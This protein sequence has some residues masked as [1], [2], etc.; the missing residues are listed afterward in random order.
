MLS[1]MFYADDAVFVGQ[2]CESNITTL[3]H[4][5]VCFHRAFGLKIN[6][7]KSK[8]LG[9]HMDS[10]RVKEVA[11]KLGCLTLKFPFLYL[12]MMVG[13][14]MS[15]LHEWD[16]VVERVKTRLSKWKMKSLSIGG[17]SL[18]IRVIQAIYGEDGKIDADVK[19]GS[20]S[21]WL[22]IVHEAKALAHKGIDLRDFMRIKLGNGENTRFWEDSW[23]E[24]D[25]L[26]NRFPRLYAL[27]SCKR[28]TEQFENLVT[29]V[30]DVS[31]SPMADRWSWTLDISRDFTVSSVRKWIDDKL[32]PEVGSKT[33][34][35][36]YVLIIVNVNAWKVKLDVFPTR[37][38]LSRRGIHIDFIMCVICDKGVETSWHLFFSCC[39]VRQMIR[40]ITRWWDVPC[41]EF[42]DYDD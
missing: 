1:H 36:K 27:E 42:D 12:R 5:L 11:L 6:M 16:E 41:E 23:I 29:L 25:L 37:F 39:M 20:R 18:W 22:N 8:I 31:L 13:G 40:L 9:V 10:D 4:V 26:R 32:I 34:W 33:R 30:H 38:N 35:V 14:S 2:W 24:G 7:S 15:R 19:I 3:V 28:I 21:C 17:N